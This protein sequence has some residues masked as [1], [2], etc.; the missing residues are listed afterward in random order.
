MVHGADPS[1]EPGR[2]RARPLEPLKLMPV[3]LVDDD[4]SE[5]AGHGV[6]SAGCQGTSQRD[7]DR[8][9]DGH[10]IAMYQVVSY[11]P[12]F[13]RQIAGLQR[14]LWRGS[15]ALNAAYFEWKYERNPFLTVPLLSLAVH[16]GEV[17]GMRGM[18][19]SCWEAGSAAE[20]LV[21]PCADDFVIAPA[22]RH[23][24]LFSQIIDATVVQLAVRGHPLTFSLSAGAAAMAGSL[25]RGWRSV[26]SVREVART[27]EETSEPRRF[28]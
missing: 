9:L 24:G 6:P 3:A 22:H 17:V 18:F 16:E 7:S 23:S 13:K 19:G 8:T 27:P 2:D 25:V 4:R 14:H 10:T 15:E 1:A 12:E 5:T 21:V 28:A 26:G 11:L 20:E